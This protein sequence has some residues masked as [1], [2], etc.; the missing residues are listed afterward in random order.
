[1]HAT[2]LYGPL[3][4]K[5]FSCLKEFRDGTVSILFTRSKVDIK[6][7]LLWLFLVPILEGPFALPSYLCGDP[8]LA[9]LFIPF[10]ISDLLKEEHKT[11]RY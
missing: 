6:S 4:A 9:Q 5:Y 10:S 11:V 3:L 1:M 8:L 7:H 2:A